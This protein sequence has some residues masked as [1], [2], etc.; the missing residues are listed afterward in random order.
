M[1]LVY[2]RYRVCLPIMLDML[3][4][5]YAVPG[6][7]P[8]QNYFNLKLNLTGIE[9]KFYSIFLTTNLPGNSST[10]LCQVPIRA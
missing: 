9:T 7:L 10:S 8:A 6:I 3:T 2:K 5:T 1:I 4:S